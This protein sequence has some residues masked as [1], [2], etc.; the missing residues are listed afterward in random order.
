MVEGFGSGDAALMLGHGLQ[1]GWW[2]V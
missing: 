1:H 2:G